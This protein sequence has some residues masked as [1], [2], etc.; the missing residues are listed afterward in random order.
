MKIIAVMTEKKQEQIR[1]QILKEAIKL[2][3]FEIKTFKI[4][5]VTDQIIEV[6][7]IE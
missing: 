5:P 3:P 4:N 1:A 7:G 2:A 6:N